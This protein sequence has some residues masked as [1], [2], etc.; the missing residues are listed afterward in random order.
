[1]SLPEILSAEI[2]DGFQWQEEGWGRMRVIARI[3]NMEWNTAIWFDKKMNT[4]I[5]PVKAEIRNKGKLHKDDNLSVM[6]TL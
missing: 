4:Y 3:N 5:L 6:I 2:R 1:M